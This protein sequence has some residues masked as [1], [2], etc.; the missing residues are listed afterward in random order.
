M[1]CSTA[2]RTIWEENKFC[3][4]YRRTSLFG[5]LRQ[6]WLTCV[7]VTDAVIFMSIVHCQ[8]LV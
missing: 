7:S 3:F 5:H 6:L 8:S 2:A 4:T 1:I